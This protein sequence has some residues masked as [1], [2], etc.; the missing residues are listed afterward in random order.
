MIII[1]GADGF[2]GSNALHFIARSFPAEPLGAVV[3]LK[4]DT[5]W[6]NL[7]GKRLSYIADKDE[8]ISELQNNSLKVTPTAI[9]HL[10]AKS[11]TTELDCGLLLNNN[12]RYTKVLAEYC[13]Q[14]D[15]RFIYASS[16]A[17][18]GNGELGFSDADELTPNL[19]PTNPYG[20][21]KWL[22]DQWAI[23][24]KA[25]LKIAGLRF[26]N[27]Y[28]PNEQHKGGQSSP[29]PV[30]YNQV[31]DTGT[32][33]LFKSDR[34]EYADGEQKRDFISVVDCIKVII[35]LIENRTVGG[36]FN[37]G[38]GRATTWLDVAKAVHKSAQPQVPFSVEY[39]E[40]PEK[41]KDH[42]QYYTQADLTKLRKAGYTAEFISI[43]EGITE[44]VS[45]FLATGSFR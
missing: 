14:Q 2:I 40:M 23:E 42:Y 1:T 8:F 36:I 18:Y 33:R 19:K 16:A 34:K 3:A 22:F 41:L 38:T 28:G 24:H 11:Y 26:F 10:G 43:G 9:V 4:T 35:W 30:F 17:T 45:E 21:S 15:I 37:V 7:L 39:I 5:K 25:T 12:Y 44:Y 29:I 32:I 6:K 31:C 27:V 20:F 13:L